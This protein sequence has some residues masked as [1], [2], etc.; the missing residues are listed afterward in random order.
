MKY[1]IIINIKKQINKKLKLRQNSTDH[2]TSMMNSYYPADIAKQ[3]HYHAQWSSREKKKLSLMSQ[4]T[5]LS[6]GIQV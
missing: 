1:S 2:C 6:K 4:N 5:N 3:T